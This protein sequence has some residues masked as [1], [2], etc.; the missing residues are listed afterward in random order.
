MFSFLSAVEADLVS[1]LRAL[2]R[3]SKQSM[4]TGTEVIAYHWAF[5]LFIIIAF[6]LCV[7]MLAGGWLLGEGESPP[8]RYPF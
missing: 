1:L 7:F 4:S 3:M 6:G 2:H 8:Q 5:T